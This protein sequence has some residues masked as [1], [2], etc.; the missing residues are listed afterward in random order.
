MTSKRWAVLDC[1]VQHVLSIHATREEAVAHANMVGRCSFVYELSETEAD[2]IE[3]V[4]TPC[5]IKR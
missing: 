4:G 3:A 5:Q 1:G 2:Q